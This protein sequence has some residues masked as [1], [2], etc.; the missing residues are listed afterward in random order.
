MKRPDLSL[1]NNQESRF[2]PVAQ[3]FPK[4]VQFLTGLAADVNATPSRAAIVRLKPH[5]QVFRHVD[6]GSY[7]F[8]RDRL[9]MTSPVTP[10]ACQY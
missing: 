5:A 2:T 7:Y 10:T 8:I 3:L 1:H 4:A 9:P 6:D